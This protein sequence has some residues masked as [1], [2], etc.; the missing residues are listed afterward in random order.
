MPN[1]TTDRFG[2]AVPRQPQHLSWAAT[3]VRGPAVSAAECTGSRVVSRHVR[4]ASA[5][6]PRADLLEAGIARRTPCRSRLGRRSTSPSR[7]LRLREQTRVGPHSASSIAERVHSWVRGHGVSAREVS[8]RDSP[9]AWR[10][11][12]DRALRCRACRP[13]SLERPGFHA[14]GYHGRLTPPK[15]VS[16]SAL[17]GGA[18]AEG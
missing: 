1:G 14:R 8:G 16:C 18:R 7:R 15:R 13:D 11:P 4:N 12:T 3:R 17:E 6:R 10:R 5:H 2:G 9:T